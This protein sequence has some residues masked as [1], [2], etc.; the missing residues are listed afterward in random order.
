MQPAPSLQKL[1]TFFPNDG[2]IEF[3]EI[4]AQILLSRYGVASHQ[5]CHQFVNNATLRKKFVN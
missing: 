3:I 2:F 4:F 1:E 5:F